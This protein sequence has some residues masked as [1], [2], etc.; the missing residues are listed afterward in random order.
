MINTFVGKK[1]ADCHLTVY[2]GLTL[3]IV[4]AIKERETE[5]T[6]FLLVFRLLEAGTKTLVVKP[7]DIEEK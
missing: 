3:F 7:F 5:S 2:L 6:Y 4:F 1:A